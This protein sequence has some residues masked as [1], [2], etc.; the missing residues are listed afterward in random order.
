[1]CAHEYEVIVD[2]ELGR[3]PANAPAKKP[4]CLLQSPRQPLLF[5]EGGRGWTRDGDQSCSGSELE[6]LKRFVEYVRPQAVEDDVV[7][8]Q[9]RFE[10][11][12]AV[13][14]DNV[15]TQALHPID[16]PGAGRRCD[17]SAQVFGKLDGDRSDTT[18]PCV[19]EDFLS[20][21]HLCGLDQHLPGGQRYQGQ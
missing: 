5:G 18:G 15:G 11:L 10:R 19:Y 17:K 1:M 6:H 2:A 12:R 13:V 16:V 21:F 9:C 8:A 3:F 7:I 4:Q 14:D 20:W